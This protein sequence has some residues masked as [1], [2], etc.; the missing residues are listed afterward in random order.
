MLSANKQ[1]NSRS[2]PGWKSS[3]VAWLSTNTGEEKMVEKKEEEK[4]EEKEK[5]EEEE[6]EEEKE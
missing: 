4:E 3:L 1:W 5:E 6:K 2:A